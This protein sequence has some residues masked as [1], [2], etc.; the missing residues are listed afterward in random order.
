MRN[1]PAKLLLAF[2]FLLFTVPIFAAET[3]G[4]KRVEIKTSSGELVGLYEQSHA[5]VIGVSDYT[6][7]WPDLESVTKDVE[8]V[9]TA[10]EGQGFNVEQVL[11]PT[12]R[13]LAAAFGDFIDQYGYD[14]ENRLLF[15]YSG[16]GYTQELHGRQVGYLVPS[17]APN[18]NEDRKG[19]SRK[20]LRMTQVL[21]WAKQ[22]ESKHALF[23]FDSCFSGSVLKERALVVPRQIRTVTAKPVRQFISAGS[24]GQT[25]PADSVFRPSFIRGIRGE[26]DLDKDGYVTGTELGLFLQ[27]RVASYDTGQTPQFGKIKDPLYDEGDFVFTLGDPA[28]QRWAEQQQQMRLRFKQLS[29]DLQAQ[30]DFQLVQWQQFLSEHADDNPFSIEDEQL[31]QSA[32]AKVAFLTGKSMPTVTVV[33]PDSAPREQPTSNPEAA[34]LMK[35]YRLAKKRNLEKLAEQSLQALVSKHPDTP[36]GREA[37]ILLLSARIEK[38]GVNQETEEAMLALEVEQPD[39]PQV[40][41]VRKQASEWLLTEGDRRQKVEDYE[42]ALA[43]YEKAASYGADADALRRKQAGI[44]EHQIRSLIDAKRF[45][46]AEEALTLWEGSGVAPQ[47]TLDALHRLKH[48][49][50]AEALQQEWNRITTLIKNKRFSTAESALSKWQ[51]SGDAPSNLDELYA[52]LKLQKDAE[53][54][55]LEAERQRMAK[56]RREVRAMIDSGATEEAETRLTHWQ[57]SGED[58]EGL[59]ELQA[60]LEANAASTEPVTGMKF[61]RIP[62]GSF[63]MGSPSSEEGRDDDETQHTVSVGE[64]WLGETEVTQAQWQAVMGNNPSK[65]KGDDRPVENV[66]WKDVQVFI[67]RLNNRSGKRFRLPT[68]AEW[69]YAARAGTQTARYWGDGIGS[70][71]ANCDGCGSRWDSDETA[72]VGS[73]K[74]NAFGLHDMLGNVWEWTCSAYKKSYEGSEQECSVSAVEYPLRGGAWYNLPGWVRAADRV[75]DFPDTRH[76]YLGFRLARDN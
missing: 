70:N 44:K 33:A 75:P 40:A 71:N 59:R 46:K 63:R 72:P 47:A 22:I 28:Q 65:F 16:H 4:V 25:V 43:N 64:F 35:T 21:S 18:P 8:A 66:S 61:R 52:Y 74:P 67:K 15:Y 5:L 54:R 38:E 3:R 62:G 55:R 36:E 48:E 13:E 19:F 6:A 32:E 17:D 37:P 12:K 51:A 60:Y 68:E 7:G 24:A 23:L 69:E 20:S 29:A 9:S 10:L 2:A 76:N 45:G 41:K 27:K 57:S 73:F 58:A 14:P 26:A 53:Q 56:R 49:R 50:H 30:L 11:N 42:G 39:S 31:R 34:K 1:P